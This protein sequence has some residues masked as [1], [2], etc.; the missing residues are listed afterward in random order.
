MTQFLL[1]LMS[2]RLV[3]VCTWGTYE[4]R[5][6]SIDAI[7]MRPIHRYMSVAPPWA[8]PKLEAQNA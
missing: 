6:D 5:Y 2:L 4:Y 3:Y 7:S 8:K 1:R